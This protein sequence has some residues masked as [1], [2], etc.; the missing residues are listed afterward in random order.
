MRM[1]N[2]GPKQS[3]FHIVEL[4]I[5]LVILGIIVLIGVKVFGNRDKS[6]TDNQS[7]T[8]PA[9]A[10]PSKQKSN[11]PVKWEYNE[12][13]NEWFTQ[14]GTAPAC[15]D[16]FKFDYT[17]VDLSLLNVVGMPGVY[18]GFSYK[19]HGGFRA[20]SSPDGKI[21]VKM[22]TDATLV[23]LTRYY[24]GTPSSLQYLLT[25]ETDCGIAFRFDHLHTL[26]P[27]FQKIADTT[28]EPKK[29]D[30]RS[31]P[32]TPFTRTKFRAGEL[33]ATAV[34]FPAARNFGFDF[35]VYD[36]RHRNEISKN[37]KWASIHNQYQAQEWFGVCWLD[38]LPDADTAKAKG[39]SLVVINPAK[40][41]IISDYCPNA[42]HTT[43]DFNNGQPTDG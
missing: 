40:P 31:D 23:G 18:R 32:N 19:P 1:S 38:M 8:S 30:T 16:P 34:G 39:L 5:V 27:A 12:K 36:Y 21:D 42:P 28:P 22:P 4:A 35:G 41:N 15:K 9:P 24:E 14:T 33:V 29:D 25:F 2:K 26:A 3:G 20:D 43:L 10:P 6:N 7:R 11:E 37:S 17:P 13:T